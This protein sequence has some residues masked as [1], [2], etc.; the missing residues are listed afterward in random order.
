MGMK[1]SIKIKEDIVSLE[2]AF[3]SS[4]NFKVRQR[5]Q[6]LLLLQEQKFKRQEDLAAYLGIG[7]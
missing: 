7:H 5:I 1:A 6:S 2:K 3:K 4:K